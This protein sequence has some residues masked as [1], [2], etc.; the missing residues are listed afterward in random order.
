MT[1]GMSVAGFV[2][3][4]IGVI[5]AIIPVLISVALIFFFYGLIKYIYNAGDARGHGQ[6]KELIL[7]GLAA[8][9]VLMSLWGILDFAQMALFPAG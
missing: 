6:S 9:F 1:S 2:A 7:W 8:L 4:I 3:E 5:N